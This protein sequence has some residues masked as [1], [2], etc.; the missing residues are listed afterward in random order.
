[1]KTRLTPALSLCL[2]LL[3]V[4]AASAQTSLEGVTLQDLFNSAQSSAAL[5]TPD[6]LP[7]SQ[8]TA[9]DGLTGAAHGLCTA[10]CEAMDCDSGAPQ[11][12]QNACNKVGANFQRITGQRP[13]CDCP[14][15]GQIPGFAEAASG[16]F[17]FAAC[18]QSSPGEDPGG[19]I[20]LTEDPVT[21]PFAIFDTAVN[22]GVCG[23]E[24]GTG[25]G[26]LLTAQQG[27]SCAAVINQSLAAAGVVCEGF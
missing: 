27:M 10:Y 5:G 18:S 7:P 2:G 25:G 4:S 24:F 16:Q 14:C 19:V 3:T 22:F 12:S 23:F 9:C 1:M 15:I 17:G 6:G 8:E 20:V 13:P 21:V 26:L 11:A